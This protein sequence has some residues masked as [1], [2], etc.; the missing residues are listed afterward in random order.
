MVG[1]VPSTA[2]S[3]SAV[4]SKSKSAVVEKEAP[5]KQQTAIDITAEDLVPRLIPQNVTDLVLLSMVSFGYSA[6]HSDN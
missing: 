6:N 3:S 4:S 2:T 5:P 1:L